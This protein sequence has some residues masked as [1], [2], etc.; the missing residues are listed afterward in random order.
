M[1]KIEKRLNDFYYKLAKNEQKVFYK[2]NEDQIYLSD[3]Y[4]ISIMNK[5][6]NLYNWFTNE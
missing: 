3:S 4:I 5:E 6:S 2:I 1:N